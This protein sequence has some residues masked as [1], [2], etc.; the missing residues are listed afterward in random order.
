MSDGSRHQLSFIA[1]STWGTTPATPAMQILRN[2]SVSLGLNKDAFI[3]DEIRSDRQRYDMRQGAYKVGG[4]IGIEL[5]YGTY[6]TLLEAVAGGTWTDNVLKAGTTRRSFT[7]ERYFA[8][9][10]DYPYH[11]FTGVEVDK[12]QLTMNANAIVKGQF[13]LMGKW[14]SPAAA[15]ISGESHTAAT[16]TH[17]FDSFTGSISEGGS[18]I[19]V[20]TEMQL[21][22]ENGMSNR[23]V[24]GSK[25]TL[26]PA[27]GWSNITGTAT[28]YFI[29]N[30][31]FNKFVNETESSLSVTMTDGAGNDLTIELPR[32]KYTGA[33]VDVKDIGPITMAMPFQ[34]LYDASSALSNIVITRAPA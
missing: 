30:T 11:Y 15:A 19:A 2:T 28:M 4:D 23:F 17:V 6:D 7:F 3:S 12:L 9:I 21:S 33:P 26:Q 24:V 34:A 27:I 14:L 13:G 31:Q 16:T 8:D 25:Y 32:I 18:A 10:S 20:V 29:D 5:S 1:E 22:I